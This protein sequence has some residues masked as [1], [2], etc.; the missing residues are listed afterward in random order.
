MK[1]KIWKYKNKVLKI[2]W[3]ELNCAELLTLHIFFVLDRSM[4]LKREESHS[5]Y[6]GSTYFT[7]SA[8]W[9]S[10]MQGNLVL[11]LKVHSRIKPPTFGFFYK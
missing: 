5:R 10:Q 2:I 3:I 1:N 4:K 11:I 9:F 6:G 8:S 7:Y